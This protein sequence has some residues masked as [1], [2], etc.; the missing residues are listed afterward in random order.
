MIVEPSRND[1]LPVG[2]APEPVTVAVKVIDWPKTL[3][4]LLAASDVLDGVC[5]TGTGYGVSWPSALVVS[6]ATVAVFASGA[7]PYMSSIDR[8]TLK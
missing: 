2:T 7:T 4:V 3:D 1:T 5:A 8:S 6:P